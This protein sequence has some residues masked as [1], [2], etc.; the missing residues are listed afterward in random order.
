MKGA[1]GHR[2]ALMLIKRMVVLMQMMVVVSRFRS[3]IST[4]TRSVTNG[5]FHKGVHVVHADRR[6]ETQWDRVKLKIIRQKQMLKDKDNGIG[7][8]IKIYLFS[9]SFQEEACF[10]IS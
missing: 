2:K 3:R 8:N 5:V 10:K 7:K 1:E 9:D 4:G 6:H